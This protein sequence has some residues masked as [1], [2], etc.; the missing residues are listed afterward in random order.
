MKRL[1]AVALLVVGM[2]LPGWGQR[3]GA[4]GG[5]G[6]VGRGATMSGGAAVSRGGFSMGNQFHYSG[7]TTV[8]RGGYAGATTVG[9]S[10]YPG[11]VSG[12]RPGYPGRPIYPVRPINPVNRT[13]TTVRTFY[14]GFNRVVPYSYAI[15]Y[16]Y[17][18]GYYDPG[19]YGDGGSGYAAPAQS[20]SPDYSGYGGGGYSPAPVQQSVVPENESYRQAYRGMQQPPVANDDPVTLIYKDGRPPE[21]IRNYILSRTTLFVPDE[22]HREI[23]VADLDLDATVKVNRAAGVDFQLPADRR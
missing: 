15:P 4:R 1:A 22:R 11:G 17:G 5:G 16:A 19:F 6:G 21:Q 20:Y 9:R 14:P 13:V 23:A 10:G 12:F 18:P 7:G 2:V 8:G 3:G